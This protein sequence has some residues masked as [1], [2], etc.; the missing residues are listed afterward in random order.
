[1]SIKTYHASTKKLE[2]LA[3]NVNPSDIEKLKN[4][5]VQLSD[6]I[7]NEIE[8]IESKLSKKNIT[9]TPS[10]STSII[11]SYSAKSF[12]GLVNIN[13]NLQKSITLNTWNDLFSIPTEYR[14]SLNIAFVGMNTSKDTAVDC[15]LLNGVVSVYPTSETA[16]TGATN[17][18]INLNYII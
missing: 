17:F 12:N 1:M 13:I 5:V 11:G 14:P 3:G 6:E 15:R 7:A 18:G 8:D 4:D 9:V 10:S 16:F 2:Q